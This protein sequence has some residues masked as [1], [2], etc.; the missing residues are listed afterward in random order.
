MVERLRLIFDQL[1]RFFRHEGI[2]VFD[3]FDIYDGFEDN[4]AILMQG[5]ECGLNVR[6]VVLGSLQL[7]RRCSDGARTVNKA[8]WKGDH[9]EK[10][11]VGLVVVSDPSCLPFLYLL[12]GPLEHS[13]R[14]QLQR[15]SLILIARR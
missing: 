2:D 8:S 3:M 12:I 11:E 7:A 4:K 9:L 5:L 15:L 10:W 1:I 6:G 13:F 14:G